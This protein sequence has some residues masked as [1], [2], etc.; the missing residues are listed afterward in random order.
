VRVDASKRAKLDRRVVT[1][2]G[3]YRHVVRVRPAER[4]FSWPHAGLLRYDLARPHRLSSSSSSL[5]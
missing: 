4:Y 5:D 3:R 2:L 1:E